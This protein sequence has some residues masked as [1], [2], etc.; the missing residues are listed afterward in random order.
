[1]RRHVIALVL[2]AWLGLAAESSAQQG[3]PTQLNY[4]NAPLTD[5]IRSLAAALG[6]NVVLSDVPDTRVTFSTP[7]PVARQD[8]GQVL[9]S[10][11][12]SHG[13][14]LVQSGPIARILP[15]DRAPATGP[16]H[17]GKTLPS[18]PPLGLITQIVPLEAIRADEAV[19][20]LRRTASPTT[21]LEVMPRQNA[22]LITDRGSNVA[23]DL[24][25]LGQVDVRS[26]G[27][28]GLR[29][30]VVPLKHASAGELATT[31]SQLLGVAVVGTGPSPAEALEERSLSGTLDE[32][33]RREL[34]A[35]QT[36]R[37]TPLI[38]AVPPTSPGD[39]VA[40]GDS[41]AVQ[42]GTAQAG[43]VVGQTTIVPN[44]ATNS[45]V[46]R[47]APPNYPLLEETIRTLDVRPPQVLLEVLIAEIQ[48]SKATR[49]GIN[50]SVIGRD[51]GA[52]FGIQDFSDS[53][54]SQITDFAARAVTLGD[55]DVRALLTALASKS[56]VR[57]LSSPHVLAVN[58]E[59]ARI[60]VG[61]EV[62]FS[63]ST[64]TG[65]TEVVDRIV[66]FRNVGTQLT[67]IPRINQDGYVTVRILQEVSALTN[68]TLEAAL[69]APIITVR[70]AE[71]S[72]IVR[73]GQTIVIG[74]LIA[75]TRDRVESGVPVL[76]D[77][78]LL[79]LAFKSS[80]TRDDRSELA[81]FVTPKVVYSDEDAARLLRQER[82]RLRGLPA[83]T[84]TAP[85]PSAQPRR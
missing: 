8:L 48:L 9:E 28:A 17:Y 45:I 1:M 65:L 71:T 62:P 50:W 35:L 10:L 12:E 74:G 38:V 64:R 53:G 79:G 23:R 55:V 75:E 19:D 44:P 82:G 2:V 18:P 77:I 83:D 3:A 29:T 14:V 49:F 7:A 27:E 78:P 57:V 25:L 69:N 51:A 56:N 59:E 32:Y 54:L 60:L 47:T 61:S 68:Q 4:V 58:N 37:T 31:L 11:L 66:Q 39:T 72:A 16:I 41:G 40:R 6:Q 63:Q 24:E 85:P 73:D 81:I 30:Y 42:P 26:T 20:V 67:I 15:A 21:R 70:E 36:R 33:R 76:K 13:L 84:L 46:I 43:S 52:Q 22:V 80:T 34:E 5:V